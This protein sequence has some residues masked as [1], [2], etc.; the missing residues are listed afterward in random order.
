M[1]ALF[2]RVCYKLE[3]GFKIVRSV[4]VRS[5]L[6]GVTSLLCL[7]LCVAIYG[8]FWQTLGYCA[9]VCHFQHWSHFAIDQRP[10][11]RDVVCWADHLWCRSW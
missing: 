5:Q 8:A 1:S 7:F 6:I 2:L 3:V 4:D 9:G 10:W 11:H